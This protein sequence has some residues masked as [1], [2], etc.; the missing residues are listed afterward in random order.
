MNDNS[1]LALI[2]GGLVVVVAAFIFFGT[3][4]FRGGGGGADHDVNVKIETPA[5]PATN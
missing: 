5:A 2:V 1:G 4:M 3:D